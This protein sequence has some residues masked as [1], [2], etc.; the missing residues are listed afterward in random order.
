MLSSKQFIKL[1]ANGKAIMTAFARD[2]DKTKLFESIN[3]NILTQ[4]TINSSS[5]RRSVFR[6]LLRNHFGMSEVDLEPIEAT[7]HQ[8]QLY[9]DATHNNISRQHTDTVNK[10]LIL[11]LMRNR[12]VKLLLT[13]GLRV[14]ELLSNDSKF[15]DGD[16]VFRLNKK[17]G[18][19]W[20]CITTLIPSAKWWSLY[21]KMKI[22]YNDSL[23]N[24][25]VGA[26][27]KRIKDMVPVDFYK[28]SSHLCRAVYVK[29]LYKHRNPVKHTLPYLIM[30]NLH[31]EN[32][33]SASHYQYIELSADVNDFI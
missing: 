6:G 9:W 1:P 2:S 15:E 19:G 13:S 26:I 20:Y 3:K 21:K 8:K 11:K 16:V 4:K 5:V 10:A 22:D 17:K 31:H 25:I 33:M 23:P 12:T 7:V 32:T 18:R 14:T 24:A 28:K 30:R 27:N 29:Y